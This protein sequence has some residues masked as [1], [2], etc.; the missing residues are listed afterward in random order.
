MS[1]LTRISTNIPC[2]L[3]GCLTS[4]TCTLSTSLILLHSIAFSSER[5][6]VFLCPLVLL[7]RD[8]GNHLRGSKHPG[9]HCCFADLDP[10]LGIRFAIVCHLE[11]I[12]SEMSGLLGGLTFS[13]LFMN[14]PP[15][16]YIISPSHNILQKMRQGR[17]LILELIFLGKGSLEMMKFLRH[18]CSSLNR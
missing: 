7:N 17:T 1:I 5:P 15:A 13:E 16:S 3:M 14:A 4:A 12:S 10:I 11:T 9:Q 18:L 6:Y 8:G 2:S